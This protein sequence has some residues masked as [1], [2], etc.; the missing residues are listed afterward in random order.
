MHNWRSHSSVLMCI[1]E[2]ESRTDVKMHTNAL[3][4]KGLHAQKMQALE[5]STALG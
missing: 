4:A 2:N 3:M 1:H 5:N